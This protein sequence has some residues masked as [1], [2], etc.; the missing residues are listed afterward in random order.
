MNQESVI[1][2]QLMEQESNQL[3]DQLQIIEHNL[4][5]MLELKASLKEIDKKDVKEILANLGKKIYI[6]VEI[7]S[8]ELMVDVGKGHYVK[9][10]IEETIKIIENQLDRFMEGKT[11]IMARLEELQEEMQELVREIEGERG[12]KDE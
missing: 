11:Q 7:K 4:N 9:K 12:E 8:K 5:E 6:P 10:T 3:N 1:K 2:F